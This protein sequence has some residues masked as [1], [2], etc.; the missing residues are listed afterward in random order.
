MSMKF[1]TRAIKPVSLTPT[2][3]NSTGYVDGQT[4]F[5]TVIEDPTGLQRL[6]DFIAN[7]I[8]ELTGVIA[9]SGGVL[10]RGFKIGTPAEFREGVVAFGQPPL[11]YLERA[12]ART[13]V[14]P[15]V[16][17]STEFSSAAWIGLHHEMS[18]AQRIPERIIFFAETVADTGGETP[19]ADEYAATIMID[20]AIREEFDRKGVLY[21][22]NFRPEIDMDWRSAFQAGSREEVEEYCRQNGIECHWIND[23]HLRTAQKQSAFILEP[24]TDRKLF[25]NHAHLFHSAALDPTMLDVLASEYGQENLPRN[26]KFGDGTPIP[27]EM[28]YEIR[29]VY[30]E[31]MRMFSWTRHDALVLSNVR[32]L[33]G[34]A[35]FTGSRTTLVSMTNLLSRRVQ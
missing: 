13:E 18:F 23:E 25:C 2:R 34:R 4:G 30:Q 1:T 20:E 14:V 6:G 11:P 32:C 12:A 10:F 24:G 17:T 15:G 33:H 8:A 31:C 35:P 5:I 27:D 7:N 16:F 26:V 19:V 3:L 9:A 22:R 29:R 28:I 21:V